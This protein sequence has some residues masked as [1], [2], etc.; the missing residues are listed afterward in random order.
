MKRTKAGDED[1]ERV[2]LSR[3][4][5]LFGAPLAAVAVEACLPAESAESG[6]A[7]VVGPG[8]V[9]LT[10]RVNGKETALHVEPRRT[11]AD[12]LRGELG[13]TGTKVGCDRGAC[14]ACSWPSRSNKSTVWELPGASSS[15]R[16]A[17]PGSPNGV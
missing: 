17:N 16:S 8:P 3:R 12:V 7:P 15:K 14:S 2:R 11:L 1:A 9:P 5:F 13:L 4:G 10:L 6:G